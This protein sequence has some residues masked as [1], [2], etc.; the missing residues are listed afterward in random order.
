MATT[1]VSQDDIYDP[2]GEDDHHLNIPKGCGLRSAQVVNRAAIVHSLESRHWREREL[3]WDD[4]HFHAQ[5]GHAFNGA[6]IQ[7]ILETEQRLEMVDMERKLACSKRRR[8]ARK[9]QQ[10]S[11][12]RLQSSSRSSRMPRKRSNKPA[13]AL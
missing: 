9:Q 3:W 13:A 2:L 1:P 7:K 5:A 12:R 8:G 10:N 4:V 11:K 6:L